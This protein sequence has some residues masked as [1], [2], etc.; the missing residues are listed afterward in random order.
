M[1][2]VE[3][4]RFSRR[5]FLK[6]MVGT[7]LGLAF[8]GNFALSTPDPE[9][10]I[11][12]QYP[13]PG[14]LEARNSRIPLVD[15]D[16]GHKEYLRNVCLN[17]PV[18][19][20]RTNNT[21]ILRHAFTDLF[22]SATPLEPPRLGDVF[23]KHLRYAQ[24][25][26][27]EVFP[28][29][30]YGEPTLENILHVAFFSFAAVHSP[31]F[32]RDEIQTEFGTPLVVD[33]NDTSIWWFSYAYQNVPTV[34][35]APPS[36]CNG[37]IADQ[38]Y[39]CEGVDRTVHFAQHAVLAHIFSYALKHD[40]QEVYTSMPRGVWAYVSL[41]KDIGEKTRRLVSLAGTMW[42]V[43][44]TVD[45]VKGY[46][47]IDEHGQLVVTGFFDPLVPYDFTANTLGLEIALALTDDTR[48]VIT[49]ELIE[50]AID[51]LNGD[52]I[53]RL[54]HEFQMKMT[55]ASQEYYAEV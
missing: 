32:S 11:P 24:E 38:V 17:D 23:R 18:F 10:P 30:Q 12:V 40:L 33:G 3:Q 19:N 37:S 54:S 48:T 26:L 16:Q 2:I 22:L 44:E 1:A 20:D 43:K 49:G 42:E 15:I 53:N 4:R 8:G 25:R 46:T 28:P 52:N 36:L 9:I 29:T 14:W 21:G 55:K 31:Y 45:G 39:R 13:G 47:I 6:L 34:F 7:G 41:G 50:N 5:N 35:P 51:Y 27:E